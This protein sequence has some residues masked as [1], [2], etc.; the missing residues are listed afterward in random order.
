M[1]SGKREILWQPKQESGLEHLVLSWSDTGVEADGFVL[2]IHKGQPFRCQY[3][4]DL[5][6]AWKVSLVSV[7]VWNPD[8]HELILKS[9]GKGNWSDP[10][11]LSIPELDGCIDTDI[12]VTPFT[13]TIPIRR[14]QLQ[15][16]Q[17]TE[18][19]V[20]YINVPE[21]KLSATKQ[22]YTCLEQTP[23]E[24]LYRYEGLATGFQAEVRVDEM[25]LVIDYGKIWK[26]VYP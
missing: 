20:A 1:S 21:L 14:L 19:L 22:R 18:L 15:K 16:G 5:D 7:N 25:G 17:S 3:R 26:R 13:N 24:A 6:T 4:I 8:L 9:D 12:A 23:T 2:G 10:K 11:G